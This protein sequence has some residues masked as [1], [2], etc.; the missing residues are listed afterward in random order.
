MAEERGR[1]FA[2]ATAVPAKRPSNRVTAA[3]K[4]PP[5]PIQDKNKNGK[6]AKA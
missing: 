6:Y 5:P 3:V 4:T 1:G 2:N